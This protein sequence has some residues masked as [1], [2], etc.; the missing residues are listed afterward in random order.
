MNESCS[1]IL[2]EAEKKLVE[3]SYINHVVNLRKLGF[4]FHLLLFALVSKLNF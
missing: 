1:N 4:F 2:H 3:K